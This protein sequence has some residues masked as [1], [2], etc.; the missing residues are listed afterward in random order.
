MKAP[1][2]RL[3]L[4]FL[5]A[6]H[7][8]LSRAQVF[9]LDEQRSA[10]TIS[11]FLLLDVVNASYNNNNIKS[12]SE[13]DLLTLKRNE[14]PSFDR[15]AIREYDKDIDRYGSYLSLANLGSVFLFSVYDERDLW[16]NLLVLSEILVIQSAVAHWSK[17]IAKRPRPYV[18][19]DATPIA[20]KQELDARLSFFSL[21]SST[22]FSVAVYNHYYQINSER[23]LPV[24][25]GGYAMA[26]TIATT[27]VLS[28]SHHPSDVIVGAAVGSLISYIVCSSHK[29]KVFRGV[30]FHPEYLGYSLSF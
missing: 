19:D 27:R 14:I 11:A 12:L 21:H 1:L 23:N 26:G 18:Y 4:L 13:Y 15:W 16:D 8:C 29:S 9:H 6:S 2:F 7:V 10:I 5:L 3:A 30:R 24:I 25:L 17:S 20:T 22:A 28:G